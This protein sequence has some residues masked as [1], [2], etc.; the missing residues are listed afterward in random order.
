MLSP[1]F[2]AVYLDPL[3]S[4]LR[5]EGIG[6]HLA[7][8]FM[9]AVCYAD[10]LILLAPNRVAAQKMVD[11]CEKFAADHNVKFS[12]D[13]DPNRSKCKAIYVSGHGVAASRNWFQ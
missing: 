5:R 2:W 6:C 4:Q 10:D 8:I 1:T 7:G 9:G 12:T 11:S 13:D 3:L